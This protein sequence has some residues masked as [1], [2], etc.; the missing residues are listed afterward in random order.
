METATDTK[1]A[2]MLF[3]RA[4]LIEQIHSYEKLFFNRATT[5][6][7]SFSPAMNE[8]LCATHHNLHQQE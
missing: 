1:S 8:S 5:I 6:S 4:N 2:V 3:N 7:Y